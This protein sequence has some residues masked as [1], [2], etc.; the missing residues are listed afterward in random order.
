M[1]DDLNLY[2]WDACLFYEYVKDEPAEPL[3]KQAVRELLSNNKQKRNRI[4]TSAITHIEVLP[5]KLPADKESEYW[6]MFNSMHFF[7]IEVG[8]NILILAREIKNFYYVDKD[9]KGQYR[10]MSTGDA[11]QLATAIIHNATEFHTRDKNSKGG[12]VK[13]LGLPESSPGGK[14]CGVYD[15]KVVNPTASQGAFDLR[16]KDEKEEVS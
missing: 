10:L 13:L 16:G 11:V 7:D 6:S 8:R 5:K 1:A 4:C 9:D 2:H 3:Q 14:I 15:L 12:N